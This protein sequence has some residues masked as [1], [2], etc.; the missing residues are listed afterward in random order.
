MNKSVQ[1]LILCALIPLCGQAKEETLEERKQR[2]TR[3][4]MREQAQVSQSELY[5]PSDRPVED[6]K[7]TESAGYE[8]TKDLFE[9]QEGGSMPMPARRPMP[10]PRKQNSNWLLDTEESDLE[11]DPYGNP[12]ADP[13]A[14][15]FLKKKDEKTDSRLDRSQWDRNRQDSSSTYGSTSEDNRYGRERSPYSPYGN[16]EETQQSGTSYSGTPYGTQKDAGTSQSSLYGSRE[17]NPYSSQRNRSYSSG[18]LGQQGSGTYGAAPDTGLLNAA[19][20]QLNSSGSGTSRGSGTQGYGTERS[21]GY[22]PS[23]QSPY[24]TSSDQQQRGNSMWGTPPSQSRQQDYSQPSSFQK[25][26]EKN[27]GFDPGSDDAYLNEIMPG[28]SR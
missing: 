3:K 16:R 15:P 14:D 7:V 5:V 1:I 13:F 12:Y 11:S 26:K 23:Y 19:Y 4:Y 6:E 17:S 25:W 22:T 2:I 24:G 8:D 28:Q 20:P 27:K 9:R 10:I 21:R 18:A